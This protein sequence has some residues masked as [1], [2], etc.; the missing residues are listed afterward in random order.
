MIFNVL[1][2]EFGEPFSFNYKGNSIEN[3]YKNSNLSLLI[4]K[5]NAGGLVFWFQCYI[6][7]KSVKSAKNI[8]THAKIFFHGLSVVPCWSISLDRAHSRLRL[9]RNETFFHSNVLIDKSNGIPE[10]MRV[11][12]KRKEKAQ[13]MFY[14]DRPKQILLF[15]R[16]K[17]KIVS[18]E[19]FFTS[20]YYLQKTR[21]SPHEIKCCM[22]FKEAKMLFLHFVRDLVLQSCLHR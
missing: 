17:M 16:T 20:F 21:R 1:Y 11:R 4:Q 2:K 19:I 9:Y 6:Q 3:K 22:R 12:I 5:R 15:H 14:T 7:E 13:H 18:V 8:F 10:L